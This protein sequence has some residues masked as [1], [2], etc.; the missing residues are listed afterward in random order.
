MPIAR[1]RVEQLQV[2]KLIYAVRTEDVEQ[3]Q[4]LCEKGV[5]HLVNYNDPQNGM[6]ALIAAVTQNNE[7]M[8][9]FLL[10]LGAHPDV[11]DFTGRTAVMHAAEYGHINALQLLRDAKANP[12][13]Q[14]LE[15]RDAIY[16]CFTEPTQRHKA[17][18]KIL[19]EMG[20][21]VNNRARN[22]IPNLVHACL[23]SDEQEDFCI[24]LI[25]AGA[26]VQLIDEKTKRTALHNACLSGNAKVVRELLRAKADPNVLDSKQSAP[27]HEAAKGGHFEVIQ[28]LSGFGAKFDV[29]DAL[30]N[31]PIHYA[32]SSNAGTAIRFLG[33]R[34][35]NPKAKNLEGLIPKKIADQNKAKDAK[36][37]MRKAEKGYNDMTTN[38]RPDEF[39]D[40]KLMLY[41]YVYENQER[42][43]KIFEELDIAEPKTGVI[44]TDGFKKVLE[45]E[46]YFSF[47]KPDDIKDICEKHEKD[48][49]EFDYKA[50][51]TG[52]KYL[53]K[54]YL[55]AA[56]AGKKKKKKKPKKAKKQKGALPIAIQDEGPRTANGNPPVIYA[57]QH[58]HYTDNTR[59]SRDNLPKNP[60]EDDS[61]WYLDKPDRG[62]VNLCDAAYRGDLQT[63]LDAFKRGT[64]VDVTD[65][66]MKTP[67]MVACAHGDL[68]TVRF[69]LTCGADVNKIDNFKWTPLHHAAHSGIL[70]VVQV[71]VE[72]GGA[73][74]AESLTKATP[75]MRAIE[76]SSFPVCE[77]LINKGAKATHENISGL[78][79]L[80]VAA[81][82]ADPRIYH[83]INEKVNATSGGKPKS[84]AGKKSGSAS[85]KK[86]HQS[87]A[88]STKT[89]TKAAAT[90]QQTPAVQQPRRGSLLRAAAELAKSFENTE[91]IAFHPKTKWTD[92]PTTKE[93]LHEKGVVRDRLGWEVDFSDFKMPFMSNVSKRLE[94]MTLPEVKI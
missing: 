66:F 15:G 56:F 53:T 86:R 82:F 34:G 74:N 68:K 40:W 54:P 41:D 85:T 7:K 33:Q 21:D 64:S 50:F 73:I 1:D 90:V 57:P 71:I 60:L 9:Q 61:P 87:P 28:V 77:Y 2:Q 89:D 94:Q 24:D 11:I 78:E 84:A 44:P 59:F 67:L 37:N 81:E 93:L 38:L 23:K 51:L 70:D 49:N 62:Y 8:I 35:C 12:K 69:L 22:G 42:L 79:P 6:T 58:V 18:L 46:T 3:V 76:S 91:S 10:Q 47:L 75:L 43:E 80:T 32:A 20:A 16:Y 31:N 39:R 14:D 30:G 88:K 5:E 13:I 45:D 83:L 25:R 4:K 92:L 29:Y 52:K 65:K 26:N 27:V 17:C 55:M 48:R 19:I 36:K 63:L 72:A